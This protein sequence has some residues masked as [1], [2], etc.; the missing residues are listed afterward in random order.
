MSSSTLIIVVFVC[1][2]LSEL[3]YFKVA[4]KFNIID[5]PNERS[6]HT[7]IT[8]RGGGVVFIIAG[9]I[10]AINS[11]FEIP[12]FWSGFI[13]ISIVSF[14]DDVKTLSSKIRM[15]IQFFS[16]VLML[17]DI[18]G[19]SNYLIAIV[20]LILITGIINA[21]NFMDGINGITAGYSLIVLVSLL[22]I[23]RYIDFI[24]SEFIITFILADI[25]FAYFNFRKIA[26][27]FAG[28]VGSVSIAFVISFLVFK[29]ILV[30][31]NFS[32]IM[33]LAVYGVD[34][35][36][37]ILYRLRKRENIFEA[38][39]SHLY[40]WLVKPGPLTHLQMSLV[41][42]IVQSI[43]SVGV[44]AIANSSWQ[45]QLLYSAISLIALAGI[46]ILIKA[47][48]KSKYGLV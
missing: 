32:Y 48:Y 44:I 5:K 40:Q 11:G 7:Q 47:K 31:N 2:I 19:I 43:L 10:Y 20:I 24:S 46:Y 14:I 45:I 4:D 37:T 23:N 39:R 3:L 28:D 16:V 12:Y 18:P 27:C 6:S 34:S 26:K 9:L 41:Y 38:H 42:M 35:V 36:L 33:L 30:T 25:V 17:F 15:P 22:I 1:S 21:Y 13:S 29:L 8:I